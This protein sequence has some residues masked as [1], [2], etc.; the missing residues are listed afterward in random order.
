MAVGPQAQ[1]ASWLV[2]PGI[3]VHTEIDLMGG[4]GRG[5]REAGGGDA[6]AIAALQVRSW[7]APY[8]II[9]ELRDD[10]NPPCPHH[11]MMRLCRCRSVDRDR[12]RGGGCGCG[13]G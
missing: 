12:A 13:A 6:A 5:V 11:T 9:C 8:R 1:F 2:P 10:K 7:Q 3:L 4:E